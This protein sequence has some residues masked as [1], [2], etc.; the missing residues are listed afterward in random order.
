M[1]SQVVHDSEGV[2]ARCIVMVELPRIGDCRADAGDSFSQSFKHCHVKCGIHSVTR[3]YKLCMN[4]SF[5]VKKDNQ[6]AF[7]FRLADP[8]LFGAR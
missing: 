7:H 5:T 3:K 4:H 2:V 6:H 1:F 8:G